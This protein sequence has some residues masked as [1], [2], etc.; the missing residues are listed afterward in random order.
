MRSNIVQ[1]MLDL[2][3]T[4]FVTHNKTAISCIAVL[5]LG[6]SREIRSRY[7]LPHPEACL[8]RNLR[9]CDLHPQKELK[10]I[11][12]DRTSGVTVQ[13][14]GNNL[15]RL[16]GFV[17]GTFPYCDYLHILSLMPFCSTKL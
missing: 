3:R 6:R 13:I 2:I 10:E 8:T 14:V 7:F 16:T 12:R 17:E 5:M 11:A 15:Q 1:V 4:S 9:P